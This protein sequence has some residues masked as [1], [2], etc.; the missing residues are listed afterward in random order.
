[1]YVERISTL[2]SMMT[3]LASAKLFSCLYFKN[4]QE[5]LP[6]SHNSGWRLNMYKFFSIFRMK[7]SGMLDMHLELSYVSLG[8]NWTGCFRLEL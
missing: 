6:T 5:Y 8:E 4:Q 7:D 1:M 2:F 3:P